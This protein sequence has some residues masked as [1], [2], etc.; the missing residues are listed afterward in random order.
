MDA[1]EFLIFVGLPYTIGEQ[2]SKVID[3]LYIASLFSL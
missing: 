2:S 3:G 1:I